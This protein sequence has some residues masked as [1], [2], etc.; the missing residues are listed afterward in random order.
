MSAQLSAHRMT[1]RANQIALGYF[2]E[3]V[4]MI[5]Q[6]R[7]RKIKPFSFRIKVIELHYAI[8]K[9]SPAINARSAFVFR[10]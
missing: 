10:N 4:A 5:P 2:V 1:V 8:R 9:L 3:D 6:H 7:L